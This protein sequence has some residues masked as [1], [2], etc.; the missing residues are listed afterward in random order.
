MKIM[1]VVL[2]ERDEFHK[3]ILIPIIK[4]TSKKPIIFYTN[5]FHQCSHHLHKSFFQ[6]NMCKTTRSFATCLTEMPRFF[7]TRTALCAVM[8]RWP[9]KRAAQRRP[10]RMLKG[11]SDAAPIVCP[12]GTGSGGRRFIRTPR[13]RPAAASHA[14]QRA[15]TRPPHGPAAGSP[16]PLH[17]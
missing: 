12:P 2:N 1:S 16:P 11:G 10:R 7:I 9:D 15:K 8:S 14:P 13:T 4:E 3:C 5:D 6:S 17:E